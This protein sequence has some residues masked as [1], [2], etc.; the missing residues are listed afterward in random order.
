MFPSKWLMLVVLWLKRPTF[1][2][3]CMRHTTDRRP[4]REDKRTLLGLGSW[5]GE[6]A[7]QEEARMSCKTLLR[8]G[9]NAASTRPRIVLNEFKFREIYIFCGNFRKEIHSIYSTKASSYFPCTFKR[10]FW[11]LDKCVGV[12]ILGSVIFSCALQFPVMPQAPITAFLLKSPPAPQ[13]IVLVINQKHCNRIIWKQSLELWGKGGKS[14]LDIDS[15]AM[16]LRSCNE[17]KFN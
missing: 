3:P 1:L 7:V 13:S 5:E 8:P 11:E 6:G 15:W 4:G 12:K 16:I 9:K 2:F 17:R 10:C 14:I